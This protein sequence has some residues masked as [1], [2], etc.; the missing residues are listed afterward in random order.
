MNKTLQP[1]LSHFQTRPLA[2][3]SARAEMP[4]SLDLGLTTVHVTRRENG[5]QLPDGQVL[6]FS[7][8]ER[9]NAHKTSCF[10]LIDEKIFKVEEFSKYTNI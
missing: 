2:D 10:K 7:Q 4:L 8:V 5:W 3:P 6:R 9:I 1:I